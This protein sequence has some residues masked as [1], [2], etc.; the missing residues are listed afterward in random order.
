[1]DGGLQSREGITMIVNLTPHPVNIINDNGGIEKIYSPSG[2]I[3]RVIQED[4]KIDDVDGVPVYNVRY[5]ETTNLPPKIKD[6][7]YI[8]SMVVADANPDRDDFLVPNDLVRY[9]TGDI[10][11]CRSFRQLVIV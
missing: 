9:Q 8:V 6:V 2:H 4:I 3:C 11:G 10:R 1:M 7:R 5:G